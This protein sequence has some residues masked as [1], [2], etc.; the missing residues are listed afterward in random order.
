LKPKE[1]KSKLKPKAELKPTKQGDRENMATPKIDKP[2]QDREMNSS[3]FQH[4]AELIGL[5]NG[6]VQDLKTSL[7]LLD[8]FRS[9][10]EVYQFC[11]SLKK[12]LRFEEVAS[13]EVLSR[14]RIR[15]S[16]TFPE[17]HVQS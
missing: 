3:L 8:R 12:K 7:L 16:S 2:I 11:E 1:A 17:T 9:S 5:A 6:M 15:Q 10:P 14:K 4:A 13:Q